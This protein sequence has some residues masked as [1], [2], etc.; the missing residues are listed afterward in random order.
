MKNLTNLKTWWAI[1]NLLVLVVCISSSFADIVPYTFDS[2]VQQWENRHEN[3]IVTWSENGG[4]DG[5][6]A[7]HIGASSN[8]TKICIGRPGTDQGWD[9]TIR[10]LSIEFDIYE[11]DLSFIRVYGH[12]FKGQYHAVYV[13]GSVPHAGAYGSVTPINGHNDWYRVVMEFEAPKY[14]IYNRTHCDW[15][16]GMILDIQGPHQP[17]IIDNIRIISEPMPPVADADGPY[18]VYIG[19]LLTLDASCSTDADDNITTYSWDLDDDGTFETDAGG[20]AVFSVDYDYLESLGLIAGGPYDINVQVTDS[21]L[22]SDTDTSTLTILNPPVA[23]VIFVYPNGTGHYPT[24]QAAIN[25]ATDGVEV[26]LMPGTY[27]GEGNRD[28]NFGGKAIT[29]MST[30]PQDPTTVAATII[31]CQYQGS[32]FIF[33]NSEG[34]NSVIDGLTITNAGH[35]YYDGGGIYCNSS[36]PTVA[37]CRV[38]NSIGYLG[39]AV[40]NEYGSSPT[41]INCV[42]MNNESFYGGGISNIHSDPNVINCTFTGNLSDSGGGMYNDFSNPT[43]TGCTFTGNS[44]DDDGGGMYNDTSSPIVTGCTFTSNSSSSGGGIGNYRS[45]T[46]VTNCTFLT[47]EAS[48]AGGAFDSDHH[49]NIKLLNCTFK[50]N[51]ARYGGAVFIVDGTAEITNCFFFGNTADDRAGGLEI[52]YSSGYVVNC[53]F[54]DNS[55]LYGGGIQY[56]CHRNNNLVLNNTILWDNTATYG[57]QISMGFRGILH[58]NYCNIQGGWTGEGNIDA[59]PVFF[60]PENV[61][62]HLSV[63]SPC[64]NAGSNSVI[65]ANYPDLDGNARILNGI[66]DMGAYEY[67]RSPC[68]SPLLFEFLAEQGEPNP[69]DQVLSIRNCGGGA[70]E[71]EIDADVS[72]LIVEPNNDN[73]GGE[74][75][76]I[77]LSV[78]TSGLAVGRY[79]CNLMISDSNELFSP[80]GVPIALYV[81]G[82]ESYV[83]S[84]FFTIQ[85]ALDCALESSTVIVADGTYQGAG[86]RDIDFKGKAVTLRSEKGPEN[87]IIDCENVGRGFYF[88]GREGLSSKVDGFTITNGQA[89]NGAGIYCFQSSP[90]ITNCKIFANSLFPHREGHWTHGGGIFLERSDAVISNCEISNNICSDKVEGG[91][92]YSKR[93]APIISNCTISGHKSQLRVLSGGGINIRE[94]SA[95]INRCEISDNTGAGGGAGV[96]FSDCSAIMKNC[97]ITKNSIVGTAPGGGVE[98]FDSYITMINCTITDNASYWRG[99]GIMSG[100]DT[101]LELY[102]CIIWG[103]SISI[104]SPGT[105]EVFFT[106][107]P[108]L[109]SYCNI[110]GG[111]TGEGNIDADPLFVDSENGDYHLL[112][113][114]PC[115]GAGDPDFITEPG[116]TDIDGQR[117][118]MGGRI[119]IGADEF[120]VNTPPVA[121]A[122]EDQVVYAW[123]DGMAQV[124][125]DGSG[126]F[127]ADGDELDYF[128]FEGDVQ[129]ATGVDPNVQL[130][131]GEHI[132]ELIVNDGSEDSEPNAV[133]ITVIGPVEADVD[134]VPRVINRRSHMKRVI[135]I[136]RLPEGIGK[137]D[138]VRESFELYVGGLDAEPVG[139]IW[140]RVIGW[141]N[142]TRVFAL[143]DK[144][145]L[146]AAAPNNGR[147]DLTVVGKLESGQYIYGSDTVRIVQ[148][149]RRGRGLRKR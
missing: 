89:N 9:P 117:R 108:P 46:I 142:M 67:D 106:Q 103:N 136:V 68:I 45:S 2:D 22:Q 101:E 94:G 87:C 48:G 18:Y 34:L 23:D 31:D 83:P 113:G 88:N 140:Q 80:F 92:I 44:A 20:Q 6:G 97:L 49:S 5:G 78:D 147:P 32:G 104:N 57:A 100:R 41:L 131:V 4:M 120:F 61:D 63:T 74:V 60:D 93:G 11:P 149:R 81:L 111:W 127:D 84:Q 19:D 95:V 145:E 15:F 52:N 21:E 135:A 30:D 37:N 139:A 129:I 69:A 91:G 125:L 85:K 114:S 124:G 105:E 33:F 35:T 102:N 43:V 26:V 1:S 133:V 40:C 118:V 16:D 55:A 56:Y 128:W 53:T 70:W 72:W 10:Y 28:L 137:G 107:N 143:F 138:V 76:E 110:R 90:K 141:G 109:L 116:M 99:G 36:S 47:N 86:N 39:G 96:L 119:D 7:L 29:V 66:V 144:G 65:D 79:D 115:I 126:S 132:I 134:I 12:L 24:I 130:S 59:E 42:F 75:D 13:L 17:Y 54:V 148:P 77:T 14:W 58:V 62:Y 123:I 8:R 64:I 25:A 3:G 82:D 146:M 112:K 122:G 38:L 71:W 121:D 27:T 50:E 98:I 51:Q 73:S